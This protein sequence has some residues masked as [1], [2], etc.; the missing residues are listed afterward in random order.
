M[1]QS[2]IHDMQEDKNYIVLNQLKYPISGLGWHCTAKMKSTVSFMDFWGT[3]TFEVYDSFL[4]LTRNDCQSM[5]NLKSCFGAQMTC[6]DNFCSSTPP[7]INSDTLTFQ[8]MSK[9][10]QTFVYCEAFTHS[11][12]AESNISKI[13]FDT[14]DIDNC[15]AHDLFCKT[16]DG[17]IIWSL[18]MNLCPFEIVTSVHLSQKGS[19]LFNKVDNKLFQLLSETVICG[20]KAYATAEGLFLSSDKKFET[21]PM[22]KTDFKLVDELLLSEIDFQSYQEFESITTITQLMNKKFC[23]I[24]NNILSLA[25]KFDDTFLLLNDFNGNELVTYID[26]N[27]IFV[28]KCVQINEIILI[29]KTNGCFEDIPI[30]TV[31][32]N[33]SVNAFLTTDNIIKI[34]SKIVNCKSNKKITF[35]KDTNQLITMKGDA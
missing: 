14:F 9:M 2:H 7:K 13:Y 32:A 30:I 25:K 16:N 17:I 33:K 24:F 20:S 8:W 34:N 23:Q 35:L 5:V 22:A 1:E 28:S 15:K 18:D 26:N 29:N 12:S 3:K 27:E 11:I 10:S 21:L 4:P 31:I 19:Y 6:K